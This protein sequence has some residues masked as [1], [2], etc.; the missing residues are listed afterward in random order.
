MPQKKSKKCKSESSSSSSS[1]SDS[2]K[3]CVEKKR[4]ECTERR[5]SECK[6]PKKSECRE[7]KKSECREPKL[8]ECKE[9]TRH[10]KN[11]SDACKKKC[12]KS[13]SQKKKCNKS[14]S[15]DKKCCKLLFSIEAWAD[16]IVKSI[17]FIPKCNGSQIVWTTADGSL[18]SGGLTEGGGII[19][20]MPIASPL[21]P[22]KVC[23]G[24]R[25]EIPSYKSSNCIIQ[26]NCCCCKC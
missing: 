9:F 12:K 8:V 17:T 14:C 21:F 7:P 11:K 22:L 5:R 25:F 23:P 19:G 13:S 26:C 15:G 16:D 1:C 2:I 24:D 6:E 3:K 18:T 20:Q 10:R 4:I